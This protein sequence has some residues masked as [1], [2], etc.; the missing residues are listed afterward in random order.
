MNERIDPVL[1][2]INK[3]RDASFDIDFD[4]VDQAQQFEQLL[5]KCA[6]VMYALYMAVKK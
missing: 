1:E 6:P 4:E 2:L 3:A 5:H